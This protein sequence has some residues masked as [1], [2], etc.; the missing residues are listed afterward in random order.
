MFRDMHLFLLSSDSIKSLS[1]FSL[2]QNKV[3]DDTLQS[4]GFTSLLQILNPL[5]GGYSLS[6]NTG[7]L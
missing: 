1:L 3:L 7:S 6:L 5:L 4:E 2:W